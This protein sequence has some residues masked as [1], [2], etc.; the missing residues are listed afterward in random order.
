M[1]GLWHLLS[2]IK[3]YTT[4]FWLSIVS[5]V[6][7]SVFTVISIPILIPFFQILFDRV[8]QLPVKPTNTDINLLI[9]YYVSTWIQTYGRE[10]TLIWV[11]GMLIL[12]FLLKNVFRYGALYFMA[13]LRNGIIY[14]LRKE[15]YQKYLELPLSF[16]S[17]ERKGVLLSSMTVDVQ[18]VEWSILNVIEVVFKSPII[19]IGSIFFMFYISPALTV[20][21]FILVIFAGFIIGRVVTSLRDKSINVQDSIALLTAHVEE[22]L[23]GMR[24]IKGFNAEKYQASKFDTENEAY[25]KILTSV[26]NKRDMAAP[27]SEFLGVT[28]VT[29]LMWYGSNLVFKNE[30][31]PETFFAFVFAFYQV[32]EPAKSFSAAYFSI[33]KGLAAMDRI[34]RIMNTSNEITSAPNAV[35][36]TTFERQ[37]IF[38]EVS[39]QYKDSELEALSDV[40]FAVEKGQVVALVGSS[41]AGKSTFVDLLP[42]FYDTTSGDIVIDDVNIKDIVLS[43]LRSLYGIVSQDAILF[44]DTIANNIRFGAQRYSDA[45]VIEAAKIANAH[46]FISALPEG[47]HTNIG[48]RGLKLSGGQRQR[49][50]IARAILRNPPILIL[51]EATSA[52]DS[53][54]EKLVQEALY[55]VMKNRTSIIVAHR[56]STIQNADIIVVLHNGKIIQTGSHTDLLSQE[57]AYLKFVE[58]QS[59]T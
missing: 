58:M 30:L 2:R 11:C 7:L 44:H 59:F 21:V 46:D 18:E 12:V 29:I 40:N 33:Q 19:M 20:F 55:K 53:E 6:L 3:D 28:V 1:K 56:L 38:K 45:E 36:K 51:D 39:F 49:L 47:Y 54:S 15:L 32:I 5:N 35:G 9:K 23:G 43:D 24:I 27:V 13:P 14:D 50:T 16:Y 48:D 4:S 25:K 26:V 10:T 8:D 31:A 57:G 34:D 42:R 17:S 37:I 52:L 22:A 41:G